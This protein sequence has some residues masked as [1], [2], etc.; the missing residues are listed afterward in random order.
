MTRTGYKK[1][2]KQTKY[3]P[4]EALLKF[5]WYTDMDYILYSGR[6]VFSVTSLIKDGAVPR[7]QK[8]PSG[9]APS[10]HDI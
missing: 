10:H 9:W 4:N 3:F 7:S 6:S 2:R 8:T 5:H 1:Q